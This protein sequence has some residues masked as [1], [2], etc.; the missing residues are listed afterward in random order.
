MTNRTLTTSVL[1]ADQL[2]KFNLSVDYSRMKQNKQPQASFGSLQAVSHT[3]SELDDPIKGY[4]IFPDNKKPSADVCY[5]KNMVSLRS[6]VEDNMK[7][8]ENNYFAH[9]FGLSSHIKGTHEGDTIRMRDTSTLT[10]WDS[11]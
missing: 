9:T 11:N 2:N 4:K 6:L 10:D 7:E 5:I 1:D 3:K 8:F